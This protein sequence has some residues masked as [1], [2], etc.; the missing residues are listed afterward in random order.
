MHIEFLEDG[1]PWSCAVEKTYLFLP[2]FLP[3]PSFQVEYIQGC[4]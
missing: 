4:G 2:Y 1:A 3:Y